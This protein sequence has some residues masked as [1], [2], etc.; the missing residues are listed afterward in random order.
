MSRS[1]AAAPAR[2]VSGGPVIQSRYQGAHVLAPPSWNSAY[3][4]PYGGSSTGRADVN[5]AASWSGGS[6]A[7]ET[8]S[9][10]YTDSTWWSH[11]W[12]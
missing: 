6:S 3:E 5:A 1:G 10:R 2:P 11:S 4:R 8:P 9:A 7:S 12:T